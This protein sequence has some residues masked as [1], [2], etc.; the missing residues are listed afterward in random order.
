MKLQHLIII[1]SLVL[2]VFLNPF[3]INAEGKSSTITESTQLEYKFILSP[4]YIPQPQI[5][6]LAYVYSSIW[7]NKDNGS[8]GIGFEF[9]LYKDKVGSK[10]D[11]VLLFDA[12]KLKGSTF[13]FTVKGVVISS[14][15][16]L[17]LFF[18]LFPQ[19][20]PEINTIFIKS[21]IIVDKVYRY[22]GFSLLL[23]PLLNVKTFNELW[24]EATLSVFFF[25]P[26]YLSTGI[27][28]EYLN[29]LLQRRD[30]YCIKIVP[31]ARTWIKNWLS[32]GLK[33]EFFKQFSWKEEDGEEP[34]LY[35]LQVEILF[36]NELY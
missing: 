33:G 21:G 9:P 30:L 18:S 34:W 3:L 16:N 26:P 15:F 8:T 17:G 36:Y 13:K 14:I 27:E 12:K 7:F 25:V 4:T 20:E 29:S 10:L 2:I 19:L 35:T 1:A 22:I 6:F 28:F 32:L 11:L 23:S 31:F 5:F 24:L